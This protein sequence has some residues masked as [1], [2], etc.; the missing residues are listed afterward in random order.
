MSVLSPIVKASNVLIQVLRTG[1]LV[2]LG[3]MEAV[4]PETANTYSNRV[5]LVA[6]QPSDDTLVDLT[7]CRFLESHYGDFQGLTAVFKPVSGERPS[8]KQEFG[9]ATSC[10][11]REIAASLIDRHSGLGIVLPTIIR[12]LGNETGSLQLHLPAEVAD[13]GFRLT[14]WDRM[15]VKKDATWKK[16]ALLDRLI[17]NADRRETNYLVTR[18]NPQQ[19]VAIDHGYSFCKVRSGD[20]NDAV[21]HFIQ[22]PAEAVLDDALASCLERLLASREELL[23]ELPEDIAWMTEMQDYDIFHKAER[24]LTARSLLA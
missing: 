5:L 3:E 19:V 4:R 21:R 12:T 2:P 11:V 14:A 18:H 16:M 10:Y 7:E 23:E 17:N 8:R 6:V 24:M 15:A 13:V 9:I 22:Q 20:S 1:E